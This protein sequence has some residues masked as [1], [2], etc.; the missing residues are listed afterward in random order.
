M[1]GA[2][3]SKQAE[4]VEALLYQLKE[5]GYEFPGRMRDHVAEICKIK[6]TKLAVIKAIQNNIKVP[7]LMEAWK[8]DELNESVAYEISKMPLDNQYRLVDWR[9][10]NNVEYS[11]LTVRDI[12]RLDVILTCT[13]RDCPKNK[14]KSCS[15][16][17]RMY[18]AFYRDGNWNCAGCCAECLKRETCHVCC[19]FCKPKAAQ[20]F[21]QEVTK[22]PAL[23]DPRA[24]W[25]WTRDHFCARLK[26]LRTATGMDKKTFAE[27]IGD[28]PNTYSAWENA[29][30]PGS[31]RLPKLA[32]CLNTSLDYLFGLT[33]D[34]RRADAAAPRSDADKAPQWRTGMP[35]R[36]GWYATIDND[37]DYEVLYWR[38][39]VC[40]WFSHD[41]AI[42]P[43]FF[44]GEHCEKWL[45]LP[46]AGEDDE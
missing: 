46:G 31:D 17:E 26:K 38:E 39:D 37:G 1:S 23:D 8:R 3:I 36:T 41:G 27:S 14:N 45:L 13:R 16:G 34:P 20:Q 25:K 29:S 32:L 24:D 15:N 7:G 40:N 10:D 30:L 5:E 2:D 4:R 9:I 44:T 6:T 11:E 42:K 22:N 18:N 19:S 35:E 12:K 33:D 43:Y 21:E 28:Y